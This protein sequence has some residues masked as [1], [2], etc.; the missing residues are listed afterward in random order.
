[1]N[2]Y[3]PHVDSGSGSGSDSDSDSD[4]DSNLVSIP[5]SGSESESESE[6]ER[7]EQFIGATVY[8]P[9]ADQIDHVDALQQWASFLKKKAVKDM[10][11][12]LGE[13][14]YDTPPTKEGGVGVFN[15][16]IQ[17]EEK[18]RTHVIM[19]DSLDRDQTSYPLP[20]QVRLKL[21]RAYKNVERIDILQIKFY[22]GIYAISAARKNNTLWFSDASGT[23]TAVIPDGTYPLGTL[24]T[25]LATTMTTVSGRAYTAIFST[26]TGRIQIAGTGPFTLLFYTKASPM[27]NQTAYTEWGLGWVLGWGGQPVDQTGAASYNADHFPRIVDDYIFLQLNDTER[28]NDVDHTSIENVPTAQ[29]STGQVGHYFGKLLLNTFGSYAQ[30]F[31]EAPKIFTPV[32]GR[33][34]R[35]NFTWTDRRGNPLN[36]PDAASCDWH[37]SLRITEI[38]EGPAASSTLTQSVNRK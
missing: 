29:E 28:M 25:T 17:F 23:Y 9:K 3:N 13:P 7:I 1:M 2:V 6:S 4:S 15:T 36:G 19:V 18:R 30:T 16:Q 12:A 10:F 26:V 11:P 14:V 21:P 20:T 33:L 24:L 32:L 5:G 27:S 34:D 22:C 35:L 38:V 37:I 8:K 31:V